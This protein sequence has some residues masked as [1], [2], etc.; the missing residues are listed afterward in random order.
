MHTHAHTHANAAVP[1]TAI[2]HTNTRTYVHTHAHPP[3]HT[4]PHTSHTRAYLPDL[5]CRACCSSR[6]WTSAPCPY[7]CY[8]Y[9]YC[10]VPPSCPCS[11]SRSF[12]CHF[13]LLLL[14]LPLVHHPDLKDRKKSEWRHVFPLG[15]SLLPASCFLHLFI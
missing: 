9:P 8:S 13:S 6:L 2:P 1:H 12:L 3:T 7:P 15:Q 11:P 10:H 4:H 14:L 5:T